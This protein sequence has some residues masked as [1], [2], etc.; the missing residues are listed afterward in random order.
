MTL[1]D[2]LDAPGTC[3]WLGSGIY[4]PTG[5][6]LH[7][8]WEYNGGL[9]G[10]CHDMTLQTWFIPNALVQN[11]DSC[12]CLPVDFLYSSAEP[13]IDNNGCAVALSVEITA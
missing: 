8:Q 11:P 13:G 1:T 4:G 5:Q 3:I 6:T 12:T 2:P 10:V 9:V 7:M